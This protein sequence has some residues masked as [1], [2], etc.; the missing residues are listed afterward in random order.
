MKGQVNKAKLKAYI[1]KS[2]RG[3]V[4]E[5]GDMSVN[6]RRRP[7]CGPVIIVPFMKKN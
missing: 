3:Y 1:Q 5:L 2:G 4:F 6:N 7:E